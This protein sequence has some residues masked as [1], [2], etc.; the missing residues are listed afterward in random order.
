VSAVTTLCH[1]SATI[2]K[3]QHTIQDPKQHPL[4]LVVRGF[5]IA[6]NTAILSVSVSCS[7]TLLPSMLKTNHGIINVDIPNHKRRKRVTFESS[8]TKLTVMTLTSLALK[9][10]KRHESMPSVQ[11]IKTY[12]KTVSL[13]PASSWTDFELDWFGVD[14][15]THVPLPEEVFKAI[16]ER[17]SKSKTNTSLFRL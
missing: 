8:G 2:H 17:E 1:I 16:P 12:R 3:K 5:S 6:W 7:P 15:M 9:M 14:K 13:G 4:Y 11:N 10:A